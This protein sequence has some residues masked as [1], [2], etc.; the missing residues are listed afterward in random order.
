[1]PIQK[2][3]IVLEFKAGGGFE[4]ETYMQYFENSNPPTNTE[5]ECKMPFLDGHQP[6]GSVLGDDGPHVF[7]LQG[8]QQML[9]MV[10]GVYYLQFL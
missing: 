1:V 9:G 8:V 2:W 5:I 10:Q 4:P 6:G 7:S 3:Y